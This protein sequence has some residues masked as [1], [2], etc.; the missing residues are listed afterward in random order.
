[1]GRGRPAPDHCLQLRGCRSGRAKGAELTLRG[2]SAR[3][4]ICRIGVLFGSWHGADFDVRRPLVLELFDQAIGQRYVIGEPIVA[5]VELEHEHVMVTAVGDDRLIDFFVVLA[6]VAILGV[7]ALE[8]RSCTWNVGHGL[9][10]WWS[11]IYPVAVKG[12]YSGSG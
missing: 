10:L 5:A 8:E 6:S 7:I 9:I 11:V 2:L 3:P 1:M 4:T 12:N